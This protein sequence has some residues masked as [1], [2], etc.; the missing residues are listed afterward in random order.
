MKKAGLIVAGVA[1]VFV[2]GYAIFLL[3][4][5]IMTWSVLLAVSGILS[6]GC[7]LLVVSRMRDRGHEVIMM[8]VSAIV[9]AVGTMIASVAAAVILNYHTAF[10]KDTPAEQMRICRLSQATRYRARRIGRRGMATGR[11]PYTVYYM[12]VIN[13]EG[14]TLHMQIPKSKYRQLRRGEKVGVREPRGI[15]GWRV[16]E[17]ED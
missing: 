8:A 12:Y 11:V 4:M 15:F 9:A 7:A 14:D 1:A 13:N 5:T 6:A 17:L 2:L 3:E 16:L 10:I